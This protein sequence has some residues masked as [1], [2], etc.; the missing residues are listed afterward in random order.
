MG[1]CCDPRGYRRIFSSRTAR[2]DVDAYRRRGLDGTARDLVAELRRLG[3]DGAS[4]LEVGGGVGA[5]QLEL[6]RSGAARA[7]NVELSDEYE[8]AAQE[9]AAEAGLAGRVERRVGDFVDHAGSLEPAD[10]VVLHRVVCCYP[11]LERLLAPAADLARR[12]LALT[13][14]RDMALIRAAL[15]VGNLWFWLTRCSFRAFV[16]HPGAIERIAESRQLRPAFRKRG[17]LWESV[18]FARS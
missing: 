12:A 3:I 11:F 10:V 13:F 14:P 17:L 5:I 7:L 8:A 15:A 4:V 9:L 1:S 6:L 2:R 18:V 16:H